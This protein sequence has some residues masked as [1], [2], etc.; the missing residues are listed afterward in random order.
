MNKFL[1]TLVSFLSFYSVNAFSDTNDPLQ[2]IPQ[3]W[4][5]ES[6]NLEKPSSLYITDTDNNFVI[7]DES[8]KF[9]ARGTWDAGVKQILP[10]SGV[11]QITVAYSSDDA[12]LVEILYT[13]NNAVVSFTCG[14]DDGKSLSDDE[15][16]AYEEESISESNTDSNDIAVASFA[17][18]AATPN[19]KWNPGHYMAIKRPDCKNNDTA[20]AKRFAY[21]DKIANNKNIVGIYYYV[22]WSDVEGAT[23]GDY[24]AGD[25]YLQKEI[26]KVQ[27]IGKQF[28]IRFENVNYGSGFKYLPAYVLNTPGWTYLGKNGSG[29]ANLSNAGAAQAYRDALLHLINKWNTHPNFE[30][31]SILGETAGSVPTNPIDALGNPTTFSW[32]S[33]GKN[34]RDTIC[35][36]AMNAATQTNLVVNF[37]WWGGGASALGSYMKTFHAACPRVGMGGP[38]ILPSY[39]GV[40]SLSGSLPTAPYAYYVLTGRVGGV[41][42]RGKFPIAYMVESSEIGAGSIGGK[43]WTPNQLFSTGNDSLRNTHFFWIRMDFSSLPLIQNWDPAIL[44]TIKNN[45]VLSN[46]QVPSTY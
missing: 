45:P 33:Y 46:T 20:R 31:I 30:G 43:G 35:V 16:A 19:R 11:S 14:Y 32:S 24:A 4:V 23:R 40:A 8:H 9:L 3:N 41:D 6:I 26:N 10:K 18:V 2:N 34:L 28:W 44:A 25:A 12:L 17:G 39:D 7:F 21:Y 29:F 37:N 36:P 27:S 13:E 5:C 38:D 1:L 22:R 15:E 42:Y